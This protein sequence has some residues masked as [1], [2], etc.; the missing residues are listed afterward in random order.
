MT[1]SV[2]KSVSADSVVGGCPDTDVGDTAAA[3][4]ECAL[5]RVTPRP[6]TRSTTGTGRAYVGESNVGQVA[7]TVCLYRVICSHINTE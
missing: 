5:H 6:A 7:R 1:H 3:A 2:S 4:L